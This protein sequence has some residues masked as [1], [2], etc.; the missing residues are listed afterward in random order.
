MWENRERDNLIGIKKQEEKNPSRVE[1]Q[2]KTEEGGKVWQVERRC[3]MQLEKR[4]K[5][6]CV[7]KKKSKAVTLSK[8]LKNDPTKRK[9][10]EEA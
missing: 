3:L 2:W 5:I 4:K 6:N 10:E 7:E 9:Q 1:T 8:R